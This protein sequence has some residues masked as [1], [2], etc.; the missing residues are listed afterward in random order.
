MRTWRLKFTDRTEMLSMLTTV[1]W[2]DDDH[3]SPPPS[4]LFDELGHLPD[5]PAIGDPDEGD[6]TPGTF[7]DGWFVNI[8]D[9]N[10]QGLSAALS[11]KVVTPS[12]TPYRVFAS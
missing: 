10:D 2:M 6:I 11:G 8:M 1:G 3:P 12:G 4:Y 5:T 9:R 7:Q